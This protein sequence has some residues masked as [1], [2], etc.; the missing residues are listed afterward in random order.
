[1]EIRVVCAPDSLDGQVSL[2]F[3]TALQDV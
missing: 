2:G 1:M 3:V